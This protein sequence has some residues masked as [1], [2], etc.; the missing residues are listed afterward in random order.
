MLGRV[1]KYDPFCW[2]LSVSAVAKMKGLANRTFIRT[3]SSIVTHSSLRENACETRSVVGNSIVSAEMGRLEKNPCRLSA[4]LYFFICC[5]SLLSVHGWQEQGLQRTGSVSFFSSL[6][7]SV[8][9]SLD[10]LK[11]I[12]G[13]IVQTN[14]LN[15]HKRQ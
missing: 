6:S 11:I 5:S 13:F 8:L 4:L 9:L 1:R 10:S 12:N 15:I 2:V 14:A 3:K 7:V